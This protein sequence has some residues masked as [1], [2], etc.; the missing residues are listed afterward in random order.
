MGKCQIQCLSVCAI[1]HMTDFAGSDPGLWQKGITA[2][3][4]ALHVASSGHE[5][6][7]EDLVLV[8]LDSDLERELLQLIQQVNALC[9]H[10]L[11]TTSS[12]LLYVHV[13]RHAIMDSKA[14]SFVVL[15]L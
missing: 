9:L 6:A 15:G 3:C 8:L 14:S 13:C 1:L 2:R 5:S 4:F 10:I 12:R 7:P 11:H